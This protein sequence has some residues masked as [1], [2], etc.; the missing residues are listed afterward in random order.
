M[1]RKGTEVTDKSTNST[2]RELQGLTL[3]DYLCAC[4]VNKRSCIAN[5]IQISNVESI[6]KPILELKH[7]QERSL[8]SNFAQKTTLHQSRRFD[9]VRKDHTY[10]IKIDS[11]AISFSIKA[12]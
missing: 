1:A 3:N 2:F 12:L 7:P 6:Y 8:N 5:A 11:S 9:E 10:A 4:L